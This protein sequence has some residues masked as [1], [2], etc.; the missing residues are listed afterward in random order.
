[1]QVKLPVS[2]SDLIK[3]EVLSSMVSRFIIEPLE[4]GYGYTLGNSLRRVLLSSLEGTAITEVEFYDVVHEYSSIEGVYE[5]VLDIIL[6]LKSVVISLHDQDE[7]FISLEAKGP[8]DVTAGHFVGDDRVSIFNKDAHIARI[9]ENGQLRIRAKVTRGRGYQNASAQMDGHDQ[10][11]GVIRLDAS[12][13]PVRR[14]T[15]NVENTRYKDQTNYDR[16]ILE[17]ETN[18]SVS[19]ESALHQAVDI[20]MD[21]LSVF[22]PKEIGQSLKDGGGSQD[23]LFRLEIDSLG[24]SSKVGNSLRS[25]GIYYIGDLIQ[26]SEKDLLKTPNLGKRSLSEIVQSLKEKGLELGTSIAAWPP[27]EL[28]WPPQSKESAH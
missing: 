13:A 17:I 1:M 19:P 15:F 20:L 22:N 18:G 5:D 9:M 4:P 26:K 6:N 12:Y 7:G 14:V 3:Q 11:I 24:L 27:S 23:E 16:L 21:K 2:K 8:L 25:E 28:P 10:G